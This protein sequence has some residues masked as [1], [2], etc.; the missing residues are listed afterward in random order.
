MAGIGD[1]LNQL[2]HRAGTIFSPF[3]LRS[4]KKLARTIAPKV[5]SAAGQMG[6]AA[7]RAGANVASTVAGSNIQGKYNLEKQGLA[8]RG[9]FQRQ[10]L[11][12]DSLERMEAN[13][14]ASAERISEA[15]NETNLERARISGE[16]GVKT[17]EANKPYGGIGQTGG[18]R[19][20][21]PAG[22]LLDIL[23][24]R[25]WKRPGNTTDEFEYRSFGEGQFGSGGY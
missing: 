14:L 21:Y 23:E 13:K 7:I 4:E 2:Q 19:T 12:Q 18:Y 10:S 6:S 5:V 16:Y 24:G 1:L 3:A 22:T 17:A 20:E 9:D 15:S 8:N 11:I 25:G